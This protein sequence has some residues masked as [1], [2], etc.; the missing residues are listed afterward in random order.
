MER[1]NEDLKQRIKNLEEN[2]ETLK[3]KRVNDVSVH[4][5]KDFPNVNNNN[6]DN[7]NFFLFDSFNPFI[8]FTKKKWPNW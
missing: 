4:K 7:D 1:E 6:N 2:I 8:K 3:E 5:Q